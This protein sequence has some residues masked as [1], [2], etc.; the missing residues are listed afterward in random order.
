M[1]RSE[2]KG[3]LKAARLL[4][5][6]TESDVDVVRPYIMQ[7]SFGVEKSLKPLRK[8]VDLKT[9]SRTHNLLALYND[10]DE[11][12][13]SQL[14]LLT[15]AKFRHIELALSGNRKSFDKWRYA[16]EAG[17]DLEFTYPGVMIQI[18]E[19]ALFRLGFELDKTE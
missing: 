9:L 17:A 18:M 1:R 4:M 11:T 16:E 14:L 10:L 5:V 6:V 13:R 2:I 15:G 19:F 12:T 3:Y 7:L 8:C